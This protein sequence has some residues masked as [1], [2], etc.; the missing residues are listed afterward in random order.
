MFWKDVLECVYWTTSE[1]VFTSDQIWDG[2]EV[3][4]PRFAF[5]DFG[6]DLVDGSFWGKRIYG[7]NES[8]RL[9]GVNCWRGKPQLLAFYTHFQVLGA[10][11]LVW[12]RDKD[13]LVKSYGIHWEKGGWISSRIDIALDVAN[14]TI[15]LCLNDW[16]VW[17][18]EFTSKKRRF[19]RF[20]ER[21]ASGNLLGSTVYFG[22]SRVLTGS[23]N[24][25]IKSLSQ[26]FVF[27]SKGEQLPAWSN[28]CDTIERVLS[29]L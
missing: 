16:K 12:N 3:A 14:N 18:Q 2:N 1:V 5:L 27:I 24:V 29:C 4:S 17:N 20:D 21:D 9:D 10:P 22:K 28:G 25:F 23:S 8:V 15:F 7:Y 6:V 26:G 11:V 13:F 19:N